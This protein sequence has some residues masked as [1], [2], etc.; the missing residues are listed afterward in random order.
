V[1]IY[2]FYC[3]A[4]H[5]V[6]NFL[7]RTI[8]TEKRPACPACGRKGLDRWM[9][10]FAISKNR[11][12]SDA[13]DDLPPDMNEAEMERVMEDFAREAEGMDEN[14]PRQMARVLRKLYDKTGMPLD[15]N[16]AEAIRRMEAGEDPES[17]DE[18]L[19]DAPDDET[20]GL[21][22][23]GR[24]LRGLIRKRLPPEVDPTLYDM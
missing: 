4:C 14:D 11:Q 5:K 1:P 18:S 22:P 8:D 21:S 16:T 3:A 24:R 12:E 15:E 17:L 2:E 7:A 6:F 19:G 10:S 13:G 23:G 20:P 9:S